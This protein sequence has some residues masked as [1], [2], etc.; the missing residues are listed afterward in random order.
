LWSD[1]AVTEYVNLDW[2]NAQNN[3]PQNVFS[4]HVFWK[5]VYAFLKKTAVY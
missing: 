4:N 5:V 1:A 2:D 3:S